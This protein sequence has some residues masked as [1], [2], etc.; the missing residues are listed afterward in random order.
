LLA[1]V[2]AYWAYSV[3]G[4]NNDTSRPMNDI[5]YSEATDE[6]KQAVEEHKQAISKEQEKEGQSDSGPTSI[7]L[8]IIRASQAGAGQPLNIRTLISGATSG[9]CEVTLT[10]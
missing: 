4:G 5:D 2:F 3:N 8:T 9:T 6:E 1:I 7:N 10:K